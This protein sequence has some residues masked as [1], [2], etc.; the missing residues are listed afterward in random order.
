M[1][2]YIFYGI[3]G[4]IYHSSAK[5]SIVFFEEVVEDHI[6]YRSTRRPAAQ[7][8]LLFDA[9]TGNFLRAY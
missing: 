5:I 6:I 2:R 1:T 3:A 9:D 4:L 8:G 7:N